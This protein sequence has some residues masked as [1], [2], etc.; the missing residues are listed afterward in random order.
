M[1]KEPR[2][3]STTRGTRVVR[4]LFWRPARK[5]SRPAVGR[6]LRRNEELAAGLG[7]GQIS[8]F[9]EDDQVHAGRLPEY[10]MRYGLSYRRKCHPFGKRYGGGCGHAERDH[11]H[12][13][14]ISIVAAA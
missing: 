2:Y 13:P 3:C 4:D 10:L 9:I 5:R 7:E 1:S 11:R 14:A 8:Q 6:S 12:E